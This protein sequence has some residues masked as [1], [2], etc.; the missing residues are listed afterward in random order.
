MNQ[1]FLQPL[2][3]G[4]FHTGVE[5]SQVYG[6]YGPMSLKVS[7]DLSWDF[8]GIVMGFSL[9]FMGLSWDFHGIVMRLNH[10]S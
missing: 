9:I 4:A 5:A 6:S 3:L 7:W 10:Q 8:H 1:S 2:G